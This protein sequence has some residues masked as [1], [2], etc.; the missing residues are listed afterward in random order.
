[1]MPE[2]VMVE[3]ACFQLKNAIAGITDDSYATPLRIAMNVLAAN[4]AAA[5]DLVNPSRVTDIEFALNDL[6]A[7]AA[8]SRERPGRGDAPAAD[9]PRKW[10]S[11]KCAPGASIPANPGSG[12]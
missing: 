9:Q 2:M 8:R 11:G 3:A 4:V 7:V 6:V 1:M 12:S 5:K 10:P